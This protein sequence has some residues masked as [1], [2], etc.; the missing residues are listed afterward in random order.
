MP[1]FILD[2]EHSPE[3][4]PMYNENVKKKFVEQ[5]SKMKE[6]SA[7]LEIKILINLSVVLDHTSLVVVDAPSIQA[8]ENWIMEMGL[9]GSQTIHIR[10]AINT[11]ESVKRF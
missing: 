4:C 1:I 5:Y 7:K 9:L 10:H 3:M 11:D 8:V 6:I 2:L